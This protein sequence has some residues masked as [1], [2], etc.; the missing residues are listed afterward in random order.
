MEN[1]WVVE[2][3]QINRQEDVLSKSILSNRQT[4]S[5]EPGKGKR[6][7]L[8]QVW[9]TLDDGSCKTEL[10]AAYWYRECLNVD[11]VEIDVYV[12]MI[13]Q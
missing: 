4:T 10:I 8:K 2:V 13:L 11:R 9:L 1:N 7:H 3:E 5:E 12:E 6:N